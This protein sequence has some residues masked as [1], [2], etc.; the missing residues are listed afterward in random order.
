[1][2]P[3]FN[4]QVA[5][6]GTLFD[7]QLLYAKPNDLYDQAVLLTPTEVGGDIFSIAPTSYLTSVNGSHAADIAMVS[8]FYDQQ[9][10]WAPLEVN[11]PFA[12]T[13][14]GPDSQG[15]CC[16]D[17]TAIN[18]TIDA[19]CVLVCESADGSGMN[20]FTLSDLNEASTANK[21]I[22][23]S[24]PGAADVQDAGDYANA[25]LVAVSI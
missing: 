21:Y 11:E 3:F 16:E 19:N 12:L 17:Y 9:L 14:Q 10:G 8:T 5:N 2:P 6:T 25:T 18:C 7:G 22:A 24:R 4:L 13:G 1:M 23:L 15:N 20:T